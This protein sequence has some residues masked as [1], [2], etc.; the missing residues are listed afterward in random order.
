VNCEG[1]T[2]EHN[3][4]PAN[5]Q[6]KEV[7]SSR[8]TVANDVDGKSPLW[9]PEALSRCPRPVWGLRQEHPQLHSGWSHNHVAHWLHALTPPSIDTQTPDTEL[10]IC[11]DQRSSTRQL[12]TVR[13][14]QLLPRDPLSLAIAIGTLLPPPE[15]R[16]PASCLPTYSSTP[17]L[18]PI[19][20]PVLWGGVGMRR[21]PVTLP[22]SSQS[23]AQR[24]TVRNPTLPPLFIDTPSGWCALNT[25]PYLGSS[26]QLQ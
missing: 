23:G 15:L 25:S 19:F 20:T 6:S 18:Y 3:D 22:L 16:P 21:A 17:R 12:N 1:I 8:L 2:Q 5:P 4:S 11:R 26:N 14:A 7:V 9:G 24:E 10:R 13:V